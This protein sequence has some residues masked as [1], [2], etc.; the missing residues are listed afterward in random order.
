MKVGRLKENLENTNPQRKRFG[1]KTIE[2]EG[3]NPIAGQTWYQRNPELRNLNLCHIFTADHGPRFGR[4]HSKDQTRPNVVPR[5]NQ[6]ALIR[7]VKKGSRNG[8]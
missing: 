1:L 5:S 2:K 3:C 7:S 4:D 8:L 6:M